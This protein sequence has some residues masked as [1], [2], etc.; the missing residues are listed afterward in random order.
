MID[1]T[2][3]AS[4]G[5]RYDLMADTLRIKDANFHSYSWMRDTAA[6]RYGEKVSRFTKDAQEYQTTLY[7]TGKDRDA[8]IQAM[9][10]DFERDIVTKTPGKLHWKDSY[11]ACFITASSTFPSEAKAW[12]C[13]D[14]TIYCPYPF[15]TEERSFS[16]R[17]I[18]RDD[19]YPFLDYAYDLEYDF[20]FR[21]RAVNVIETGHYAESPFKMIIYGPCVNP[22]V[23]ISGNTYAVNVTVEAG[24]HLVIDSRAD[25]PLGWQVYLRSAAG[26][27]QNVFNA[28][29]PEYPILKP[30]PG[31]NPTIE[32]S[33]EYG[34]DLTLYIERSEPSWSSY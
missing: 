28:R 6:R 13:N 12:T 17:P 21:P 22:S 8:R 2:Y 31:G 14:V 33:Q 30:I 18:E 26:G 27:V 24:G 10:E 15:W 1:I 25:T 32:Y 29:N 23:T 9:H 3:E 16:W 5:K 4:S 7:I 19:S 11:I 34:V 20:A